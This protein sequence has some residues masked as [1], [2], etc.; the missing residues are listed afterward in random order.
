MKLY[1]IVINAIITICYISNAGSAGDISLLYRIGYSDQISKDLRL[2]DR[3]ADYLL[4]DL[5]LSADGK[6]INPDDFAASFQIAWNDDNLLLYIDVSDNE[7]VVNNQNDQLWANDSVEIFLCPLVLGSGYYQLILAVDAKGD[8]KSFFYDFRDKKDSPLRH[9]S[10]GLRTE[11]GYRIMTQ[12]PWSN[13]GS[14]R[15]SD[16]IGIQIFRK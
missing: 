12:L 8:L 16:E 10:V 6:L 7:I 9:R 2:F 15:P 14:V 3:D 5:I 13:I 11:H 4:A 1:K